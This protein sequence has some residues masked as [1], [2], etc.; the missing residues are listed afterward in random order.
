MAFYKSENNK[1][2]REVE[3]D[4]DNPLLED[5]D[6]ELLLSI[7]EQI[8][9]N[10]IKEEQIEENEVKEV[11]EVKEEKQ[12]KE[13]KGKKDEVVEVKNKDNQDDKKGFERYLKK[14]KNKFMEEYPD[15]DSDQLFA[16]MKKK[17]ASLSEEKKQ[18]YIK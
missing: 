18:K 17:W 3:E 10:E 6:I 15:L 7:K 1:Q 16:K 13:K 11:K 8:E 14:R 5:K 9:Q 12:K 4:I 2:K